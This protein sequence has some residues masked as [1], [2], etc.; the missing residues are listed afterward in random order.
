MTVGLTSQFFVDFS[1]VKQENCCFCLSPLY[2]QRVDLR[3]RISVEEKNV[4][5]NADYKLKLGQRDKL[6]SK[7][8]SIGLICPMGNE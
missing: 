5:L 1:L 6:R 8:I 2:F 4:R 3:L 7:L